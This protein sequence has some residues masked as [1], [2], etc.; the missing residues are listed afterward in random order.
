[1]GNTDL[2]RRMKPDQR[3]ALKALLLQAQQ[4]APANDD[5]PVEQAEEPAATGV[6]K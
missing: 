6:V 1:V 3:S 4:Q 2:I 5:D